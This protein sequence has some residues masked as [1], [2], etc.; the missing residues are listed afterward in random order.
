MEWFRLGGWGMYPILII[1]LV[2]LGTSAFFAARGDATVR[3]SL[4]AM[5]RALFWFTVTAV[6]SDLTTVFFY[7]QKPDVPDNMVLR[8]LLQGVGESLTPVTL[9][10]SFLALSWLFAAIGQRRADQRV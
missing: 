1:G 8:I 9:G 2:S 7:L 5:L 6:A 4:R 3:D 10:G